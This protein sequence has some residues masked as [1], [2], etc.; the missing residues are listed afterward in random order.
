MGSWRTAPNGSTI[1]VVVMVVLDLG[2]SADPIGSSVTV[3]I[4]GVKSVAVATV[5]LRAGSTPS[6]AEFGGM[7]D[8][9]M[10]SDFRRVGSRD[11][12]SR[13]LVTSA[14]GA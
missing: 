8:W 4:S 3:R 6:P 12:A 2:G 9:F 13:G 1:V 5:S 10:F 11:A 14:T 7:K